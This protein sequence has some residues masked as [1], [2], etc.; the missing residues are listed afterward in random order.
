MLS[1]QDEPALMFLAFSEWLVLRDGFPPLNVRINPL[2]GTQS[3]S[4][5]REASEC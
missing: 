1:L 4:A 2:K 3:G 5:G